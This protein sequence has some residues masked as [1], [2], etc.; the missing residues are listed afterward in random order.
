MTVTVGGT[1]TEQDQDRAGLRGNP[2]RKQES[3]REQNRRASGSGGDR[4]MADATVGKD[5]EQT[6]GGSRAAG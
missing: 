2:E 5:R 3:P 1:G 6:A 4:A